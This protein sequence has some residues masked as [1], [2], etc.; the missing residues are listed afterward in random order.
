MSR[1]SGPRFA[2]KGHAPTRE[3][4]AH[5]DSAGTGGALAPA[6]AL[7]FQGTGS[8]VGKSLIVAGLARAF[9]DRGLR[10]RPFKPQNMSNNAAGAAA[11]GG[12]GRGPGLHGPAPG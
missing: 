10:V 8:D 11:G 6:R 1:R 3:S 7:I 4:R 12:V 5:P 9:T 2:D